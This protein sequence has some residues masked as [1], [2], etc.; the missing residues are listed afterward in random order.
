I[1]FRVR[2]RQARDEIRDPRARGGDRDPSFARHATDTAG[3]ER[4]IL[5]VSAND[6][7]DGGVDERIENRIDLRAW[8]SKDVADTLR[9]KDTNNE[10]RADLLGLGVNDCVRVSL[11]CWRWCR[12]FLLRAT[13]HRLPYEL[14]DCGV[15]AEF[16]IER[17][18]VWPYPR[19]FAPRT[20]RPAL[21][22]GPQAPLRSPGSLALARSLR[23]EMTSSA[24]ARHTRV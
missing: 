4:G 2:R 16:V 20:P 15:A 23:C 18:S 8:D 12:A 17:E 21:S 3:N 7:C 22:R 14:C 13:H 24:R 10:L 1:A 5:L 11:F 19:G 9:F 6:G